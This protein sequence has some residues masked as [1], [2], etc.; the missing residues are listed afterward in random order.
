M[1]TIEKVSRAELRKLCR[2]FASEHDGDVIDEM[3]IPSYLHDNPLVR[4]I[5]WRRHELIHELG[6]FRPGMEILDFG[7]GPGMFLPTLCSTGAT[8]HA[9]DLFPDV[10]KRLCEHRTLDVHFHD[11]ISSIDE[12][13]L[14]VIVAAEVLEHIE[15]GL[16]ELLQS[17]AARL[18]KSGRLIVSVP[19]E[20][21]IYRAGRVVA[22]FGG[23]G[24]YHHNK[25]HHILERIRANGFVL[26]RRRGIP[27]TLFPALYLVAAFSCK[28]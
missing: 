3:A 11:G 16:D 27:H 12:H 15:P 25:G 9:I 10:A 26:Q 28:D 19:V 4:W 21:A 5:V 1:R 6:N 17:F 23:K 13:S 22:G 7:C 18:S 8:I 20:G 14:D 24:E 2:E